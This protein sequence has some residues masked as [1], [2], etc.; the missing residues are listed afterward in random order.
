MIQFKSLP[1]LAAVAV[2]LAA[3]SQDAQ[4]DQPADPVDPA[5]AMAVVNEVPIT[6]QDLTEFLQLRQMSGHQQGNPQSPEAALDEMVNM[7]LL[8]QEALEKGLDEDPEVRRQLE[9]T[10]TN[11]LV[12]T[13]VERYL[14]EQDFSETELRAEY[15][16]Q[17][18][19]LDAREY[20][21]RH[22][23]VDSEEEAR[24]LIEA[25]DQGDA[26]TDLAREHSQDTSAEAGGD[27]GWFQLDM[28]VPEFSEALASLEV[29]EY[30][31]TP[32]ESQ[33]GWHVILH[34]ENREM[35]LPTFE[36]TRDRLEQILATEALQGYVDELREQA[37]IEIHE[38][39]LR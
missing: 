35:E 3:C 5:N 2:S 14:E 11:L 16:R 15:D 10:R 25:L 20:R 27:L 29:G 22:I 36:S 24:V 30:S 21:A 28:M 37:T 23:L 17:I 7:E 9:R 32:V 33:F 1:L 19:A 12:N 8:R 31:Q 34:E 18:A 38:E 4:T 13:L 26:F 6:E 39:R